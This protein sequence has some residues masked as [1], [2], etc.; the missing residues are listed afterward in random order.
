MR[1]RFGLMAAFSI[2]AHLALSHPAV[3]DDAL[4]LGSIAVPAVNQAPPIDGTL[5][6]PLWKSAAVAHLGYDLRS[7]AAAPVDTTVYVMTDGAF[8][9]VGVQARQNVPIRATEHTNGVGLDTDDE[10][11][12]DLWPDG[13]K[14]FRYKFTSTP[15]GTHYQFSSENNSFEPDWRTAGRIVDGGYVV[16]MRIPLEVMHGTGSGGWRVQFIRYVPVTNDVLVWSYG[17][18]QQAFNDVTYSGSLSGLPR[19]NAARGKTRVGVYTL[20]EAA[21]SSIGGDR[22]RAGADV[23]VPLVPG[24]SFVGT[25]YPDYSNVE[26]DQESI[27]PTA[28]ARFFNDVRPFFTQGANVYSYPNGVCQTC[29]GIAE[30]YTPHIP[31]PR[32][33]YAIEGQRGLFS[34]GALHT[35]TDGRTDT[36]DAIDYVSADQKTA[37]N[38][39]GS[40]VD[41]APGVLA[42][43]PFQPF[44]V[45]DA[46]D[47]IMVEHSNLRD[48]QVFA[49]YA[50]DRGTDVL[51]GTQSQRYEGGAAWFNPSGANFYATIRKIGAYFD[52]IDAFVQHPDLAGYDLN[53]FAPTKFATTARIT[54]VDFGGDLSRY[55]DHTGALDQ[56]NT[57]ANVSITTRTLF[58]LQLTTGSSYVLLPGSSPGSSVFTPVTQQGAQIGYNLNGLLPS[59][60]GFQRGR[61]GPGELDSWTRVSTVRVGTRGAFTLEDDD[62]DQSADSG[63]R[64]VQWLERV[65]FAYQSGPNQSLALGV[66]RILGAQPQLIG[67]P[68]SVDAWNLSAAFHQK[69]PGGELYV[70]YGD[71]SA[72]ATAPRFIV[73]YIKYIGA[74]KGT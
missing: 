23:S 45:H 33:G 61:F 73:K 70:V 27:A 59:S 26:I 65:S 21:S 1:A 63:Q 14:G 20:G 16:N 19:L 50:T 36:G 38:F 8:L 46:A 67:A 25:L 17:S 52:P 39:Q 74:D 41:A 55:H 57:G 58:N 56:T 12:V 35:I 72:F 43:L 53:F 69:V 44:A 71:A 10:V 66:R 48:L 28:F 3:A 5:D 64:Y 7:H 30:F 4:H 32:E 15:I 40:Q 18:A 2:A 49:R 22:L 24:T 11:Q 29:P 13:T 62:T 34:Y 51:D 47:G 42:P 68:S 37:V 54:E 6:S 31:T 9:Y 60:V